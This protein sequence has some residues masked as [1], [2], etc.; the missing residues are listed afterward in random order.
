MLLCTQDTH[1]EDPAMQEAEIESV[2]I[3]EFRAN[4]HKYTSRNTAPI[5]VTS[6]GER[7]G[8]YIPVR[9]A[10]KERDF[11][12]LR[13]ATAKFNAMLQE[14][15]ITEDELIACFKTSR[16]E[17]QSYNEPETPNHS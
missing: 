10:P 16:K 15:G 4:I 8:F 14:N 5:A 11:E 7:I 3:R 13:Q 17:Q 1:L 2:G 6:H 12:A 9:P